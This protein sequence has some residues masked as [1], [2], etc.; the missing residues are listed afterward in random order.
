MWKCHV[1]YESR[2]RMTLLL[3]EVNSTGYRRPPTN[4]VSLFSAKQCRKVVSQIRIFVLIMVWL[5]GERKVNT[6]SKISAQGLSK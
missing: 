1:V 3:W 5:K 2:T 6:T 4:M